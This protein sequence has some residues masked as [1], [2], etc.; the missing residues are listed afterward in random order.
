MAITSAETFRRSSGAA[1][2]A[3]LIGR[4]IETV[5]LWHARRRDRGQLVGLSD[6]MLRDIGVTRA[7]VEREYGKPFWRL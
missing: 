5:L 3:E 4:A 7:D 6:R 2:A 1:R